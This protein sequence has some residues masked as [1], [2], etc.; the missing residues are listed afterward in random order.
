MKAFILSDIHV[1][2]WF[3]YAVK[4]SRIRADD[5]KADVVYDTMDYLWDTKGYP[6]TDAIIVAG[7]I[8][9]DYLSYTRAVKWL[10]EKY[11]AVYICV[12]NHD[13]L[14]RGATPSK[15]NLKFT[16][17]EDKLDHILMQDL[18]YDNVHIIEDRTVDG[19]A[20]CMGMCDLKCDAWPGFDHRTAWRR[21]W[22]D[23]K[24]WRYMNQEPGKIW[25]HYSDIMERLCKGA[26]RIMMT[27]FAPYQVGVNWKYRNSQA[28]LYFYFQGEKFLDLLPDGAIWVCGHIHDKKICEWENS[29]GA[30]IRIL[31]NP[32]GYPN[33]RSMEADV[34]SVVD[35]KIERKAALTTHEDFIIDI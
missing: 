22:F 18:K 3:Q 10:S 31:C 12:G 6:Q 25:N 21:S 1:D 4:P 9:N 19:I 30:H 33:E 16:L 15:S 23:G 29:S 13:I 27:H 32:S 35:G 26:P 8:A 2:T 28:N 24:Y 14:V 11:K 17:S 34:T 7:D 20:G 5:P